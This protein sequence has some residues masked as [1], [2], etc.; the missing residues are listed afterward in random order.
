MWWP[1]PAQQPVAEAL[2]RFCLDHLARFKRPKAYR[3]V[4]DLPKNAYG[5]VLKTE[6]GTWRRRS[7]WSAGWPS[8]LP[9]AC[10][11]AGDTEPLAVSILRAR[12]LAFCAG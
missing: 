5:K 6:L 3:F 8:A 9:T 10:R 1:S 2:D 12:S 7:R 4:A 11:C